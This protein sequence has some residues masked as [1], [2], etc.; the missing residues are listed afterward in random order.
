MKND[1]LMKHHGQTIPV[2]TLRPGC[3]H[4]GLPRCR[5]VAGEEAAIASMKRTG[6]QPSALANDAIADPIAGLGADRMLVPPKD[7]RA[8]SGS[9]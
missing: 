6:F 1:Q 4:E 7:W 9:A 5:H 8:G 3:A 2:S